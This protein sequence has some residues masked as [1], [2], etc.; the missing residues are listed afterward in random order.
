M[1]K[2]ETAN[3]VFK[4]IEACNQ[5]SQVF[6]GGAANVAEP[7]LQELAL[8]IGHR[9][10]QFESELRGEIRSPGGADLAAS[11]AE[12]APN[13]SGSLLVRGKISLA[14]ILFYYQQAMKTTLLDAVHATVKRQYSEMQQAYE[15]LVSL[16]RAA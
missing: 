1:S 11:P 2:E 14:L 6:L 12:P 7:V 13:D 15:G 16:H 5:G 10:V 3:S 9:L 8:R 4:L